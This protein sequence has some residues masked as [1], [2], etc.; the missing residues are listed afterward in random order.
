[1]SFLALAFIGLAAL[2]HA[3]GDRTHGI[4]STAAAEDALLE[5]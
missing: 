3:M 1:V 5:A 4:E 2:R